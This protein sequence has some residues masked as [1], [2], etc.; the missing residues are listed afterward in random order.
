MHNGGVDDVVAG[1]G[2]GRGGCGNVMCNLISLSL[3]LLLSLA[4]KLIGGAEGIFQLMPARIIIISYLHFSQ[5]NLKRMKIYR[6][7]SDYKEMKVF[8]YLVLIVITVRCLRGRDN[9][10]T[11]YNTLSGEQGYRLSMTD[12]D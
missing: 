11:Y 3:S 6:N 5:M 8:L 12:D 2:G 1:G 9:D 7:L 4:W 10:N